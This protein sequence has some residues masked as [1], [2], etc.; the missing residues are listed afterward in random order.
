MLYRNYK[1]TEIEEARKFIGEIVKDDQR[2]EWRIVDCEATPGEE[3]WFTVEPVDGNGARMQREGIYF[4]YH[5]HVF[6]VIAVD[7]M[8]S[9]IKD[10]LTLASY[11]HFEATHDNGLPENVKK[12]LL[13]RVNIIHSIVRNELEIIKELEKKEN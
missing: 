9:H 13:E 2:K 4:T 5:D 7:A 12:L 11:S 10:Y 3:V 6:G 8:K 1:D